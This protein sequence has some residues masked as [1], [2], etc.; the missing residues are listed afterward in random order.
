[1]QASGRMDN[2]KLME[3]S[4]SEYTR[5]GPVG[6]VS[7]ELVVKNKFMKPEELM[8]RGKKKEPVDLANVKAPKLDFALNAVKNM[9]DPTSQFDDV[10]DLQVRWCVC[11]CLC[12]CVFVFRHRS[13]VYERRACL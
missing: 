1:M 13:I 12:V 9:L 10:R 3:P 2:S 6:R 11:V 4:K 7:V 8:K 5:T